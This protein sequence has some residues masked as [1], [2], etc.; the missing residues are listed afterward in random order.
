MEE[1]FRIGI[2]IYLFAINFN[3][4]KNNNED[5]NWVMIV[6]GVMIIIS[7]I[8]FFAL[9]F[10]CSLHVYLYCHKKATIDLIIE[11]RKTNRIHP[12]IQKKIN[13]TNS[14]SLTNKDKLDSDI[15]N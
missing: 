13:N 9:S 15:I 4:V 3:D 5:M 11:S 7:L 6:N 1:A 10:L 14:E 12:S 8:P 2:S